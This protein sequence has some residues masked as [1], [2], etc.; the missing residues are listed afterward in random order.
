MLRGFP[1]APLALYSMFIVVCVHWA[2]PSVYQKSLVSPG[3][4]ASC[5]FRTDLNSA[6]AP[7][8]ASL[9]HPGVTVLLRPPCGGVWE[10]LESQTAIPDPE[11]KAA[12]G[13]SKALK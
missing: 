4:E 9:A 13:V 8:A 7:L 11:R 6:L 10:A 3:T 5:L 2:L 12:L 1:R